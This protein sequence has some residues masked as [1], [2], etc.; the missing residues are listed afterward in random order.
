[1]LKSHPVRLLWHSLNW[2]TRIAL[3]IALSI[4]L[5]SAIIV[6]TLR[7]WLLPNI[8]QFHGQIAASISRAIGNPVNIGKI[9]GEW[10]GLQP[11][12][13]FTDVR[14]LDNRGQPALLL[15]HI[16]ASLSWL[17]IPTLQLRLSN[18]E[19]DQP[20]LLV[21]RD[22][23]GQIYVG[24]IAVKSGDAN[25]DLSN[26]VLHQS[27]ILV[28][29]AIIVWQDEKRG[30]PPLVLT[31]VN[32]L[33]ANLFNHHRFSLR[34][35][36]PQ[37]VSA[38]LDVR[39]DFHG[40]QFKEPEGWRGRLFVEVDRTDLQAWRPWITPPPEISQGRGALRAWL[41]VKNGKPN[42]LTTDLALRDVSTQLSGNLPRMDVQ[43]LRGRAA[44]KKL[45]DGWEVETRRL[46]MGLK[47]GIR[48]HP[49]DFYFRSIEKSKSHPAS[50][51]LR[52][53]ALQLETLTNLS[54]F[55][56]MDASLREKL[57][58][59]Q[60]RGRASDLSLQ[61]QIA[62]EQLKGYKVKGQFENLAMQQVGKLPGFSN[63]TA[64]I[65]G[66]ESGGNLA[67]NSRNLKVD[68]PGILREPLLF[69]TLTGQA[70]WKREKGELS[71]SVANVSAVNDDLAGNAYGSYRTKAGTRGVIDLTVNLTR[72][73]IRRA[74]RYTPLVALHQKESDWLNSALL[75]GHTEDFHLR[76]KG[77]L[78]EFPLRGKH[79]ASF[80]ITAHAE[81]A[82]MQFA[83]NW[84]KIENLSGSF[85]I[86]DNRLE[87]HAP[88][89]TIMGAR[90]QDLS[91]VLPDML[92][93]DIPMEIQGH[94][95]AT[96][97]T[98]LQF[99]QQSPVSG[100]IGGFTDDIKASGD[101]KLDLSAQIPLSLSK[102]PT[103]SGLFKVQ[104]SDIDLGHGAPMLR[105]ARGELS[106]TQSG[107]KANNVT[108]TIL[109]GPA[110][111]NVQTLDGAVHAALQG[112]ANLDA[113]RESEMNPLMKQLHG[114]TTWDA[115]ISVAKKIVNLTLNSNLQGISSSLPEPLAKNA[116][117]A[118]P[119]HIERKNI[120]AG[121][122]MISMRLAKLLNARLISEDSN[123][124]SAITRGVVNLG[125]VG[126]AKDQTADAAGMRTGIWIRGNLPVLS[127]QGWGGLSE[128]PSSLPIA[129]A[130]LHIDKLKGF[131]LSIDGLQ[132]K[133]AK[134]GDSLTAQLSGE[135]A[136]GDVVWQ[137]K[138]YGGSGKLV[139]HMRNLY[140]AGEKTEPGTK[141]E[142]QPV[143]PHQLPA[144]EVAIEDLLYKG[145][146]IGRF[147]LV[148]FPEGSDWRLRRLRI[149]NPDGTVT[150]DGYWRNTQTQ[151][152]LLVDISNAGKILARS[153]YPNTVKNGSG[154]L[155]ANLNWE[156]QPDD[157]KYAT[158]DGTLN[159]NTGKG[160]FLKMDPG[161]G[162][163]LGILSLQELPKRIALD[164]TDVF[165]SGFEFDS[166]KGNA[167]IKHGVMQTDDLHIDGSSAKVL[168]KGSVNLNDET[169]DLHIII[170]PTLGSSISTLSAFAAGP[171]VGIGT[172]IVSKVLG[173]PLDK[174]MSFEYNVSGTWANPN[175]VKV[176]EKP[177]KVLEAPADA[178]KK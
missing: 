107:I 146:N 62:D 177:V 165:S 166:I 95:D 9:R 174:L 104:N 101:G 96:N 65:D 155:T 110:R 80:E 24:S 69:G 102:P 140:L 61:W 133:A 7:Y 136:N 142:T 138:G 164:F 100:Y 30:A 6:V 75:S 33:I 90:I 77:N 13:D 98:F 145:K 35:L 154:K 150:G 134:R 147:E 78:S 170:L 130:N 46:A 29:N 74:A 175:V 120:A 161:F 76:L 167:T 115:N 129:G 123:G 53:N 57:N 169:Q 25:P 160:Q 51:E 172:L 49:T 47:N 116:E 126:P 86:R 94:A 18:L 97:N 3:V 44:W 152:N 158:L 143:S 52:A 79:D 108:A 114:S 58:A 71:I 92:H 85:L 16:N 84:P 118:W 32:L 124:E 38:P 34:A 103:V 93:A 19:I 91:V 87:L 119:L 121:Q 41:S 66:S 128:G 23:Q 157:F 63:L 153:G 1:M 162:K 83:K 43:Y 60:P 8:E 135:Q 27:H 122:Y 109:G 50:G 68:A 139:A 2:L 178:P 112:R 56:P 127:M 72:G 22:P 141:T 163:L 70:S 105:N 125:E 82:S 54:E 89:A 144:M 176:G 131:G 149:T 17:S 88:T 99:V 81:D 21:R 171:V 156:G 64:S 117:E 12:L 173:N 67:I 113:L 10:E 168:M 11:Y 137:P 55:F 5:F 45:D 39:G 106:F 48:L 59:Y 148:G 26:W 40:R 73:D 4:A 132:I 159:L 15:P 20:E 31:Q 42:R 14:I 111:L 36:P 37:E 28:R 151:V